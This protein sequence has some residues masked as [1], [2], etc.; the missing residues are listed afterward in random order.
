MLQ[1]LAC[2]SRSESPRE[3]AERAGRGPAASPPPPGP[4]P[5]IS[6]HFFF[7]PPSPYLSV[8]YEHYLKPETCVLSFARSPLC[9]LPGPQTTGHTLPNRPRPHTLSPPCFLSSVFVG[10]REHLRAL[11]STSIRVAAPIRLSSS[12]IS[13]L[14]SPPPSPRTSHACR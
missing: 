14:V 5:P 4:P 9:S 12:T 10:L 11:V 3:S 2:T 7:L 8:V 1:H 6:P 13:W